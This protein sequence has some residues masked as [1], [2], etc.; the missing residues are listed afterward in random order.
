MTDSAHEP[1]RHPRAVRTIVQH[2]NHHVQVLDAAVWP[3]VGADIELPRDGLLS[4]RFVVV[5]VW[6]ELAGDDLTEDAA[7]IVEVTEPDEVEQLLPQNE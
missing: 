7:I 3:P 5:R 4:T 2:R 6:M 1:H